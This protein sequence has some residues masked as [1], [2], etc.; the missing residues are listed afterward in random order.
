MT[1]S[2][3]HTDLQALRREAR[4]RVVRFRSGEATADETAELL[5]WRARSDAHAQALAEAIRLR[6]LVATAGVADQAADGLATPPRVLRAMM[7]R[8]AFLVGGAVA[9]S[10]AGA[11]LMATHPP[12]G[13]WPSLA[14]LGSDYRTGKGQ[15]RVVSVAQGVAVELNTHTALGL[16]DGTRGGLKLVSGEIAV[17]AERPVLVR[18]RGGEASAASGRFVLRLDG[19]EACVTCLAGVVKIRTDGGLAAVLAAGEQLRFGGGRIG[20]SKM[21]DLAQVDAWRRGLLIFSDEPLSRVVDEINRYRPGRI[22]LANRRLAGIPVNA[23]FQLDRM[24]RA[25]SQ[26]RE[27]ADARATT[28][29][30]GV[31]MLS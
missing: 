8:R 22:V 1:H 20:A 11:A 6:R 7:G 12:L 25:L 23:V 4:E 17:D 29:P 24:D 30:G 31:V 18:V 19:V 28:L 3:D 9:A 27:V 21:V 26:I 15:R 16:G 14:E 2:D 13:L 5:R 10:A